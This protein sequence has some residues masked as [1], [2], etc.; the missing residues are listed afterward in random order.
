MKLTLSSADRIAPRPSGQGGGGWLRLLLYGVVVPF[1]LVAV[2][3]SGW[4]VVTGETPRDLVEAFLEG[5]RITL[6][7]PPHPGPEKPAAALLR[8][9]VVNDPDVKVALE[10]APP[11]P[12]PAAPAQGSSADSGPPPIALPA[13]PPL[14]SSPA[15]TPAAASPGAASFTPPPP[16]PPMAEPAI[17][18]GGEALAPPSFGQ[19]PSPKEDAKP[20]PAAPVSN[21][22]RNTA[23]G[24]LP[25]IAGGRRPWKVYARPAP[26]LAPGPRVAV[27][28]TGLGLSKDATAAAIAKLPADVSL[29]FSPYGSGLDGWIRRARE[30]GHEV[31]LDLPLEPPNY[32]QHDAGPMAVLADQ[33]PAEA[34]DHLEATL[35]RTA[36]YVGV[37]ASLHSPVAA[38]DSW[39]PMLQDLRNR[40]LL[41]VG[42]GLVGVP[43]ADMPAAASVTLV[44]DETPFR[45]AIDARLAR[46]LLAAGR[47][48]T[49]ITT[50]SARP[51]SFERL[52]AWLASLPE[53]GVTLVPV[54]AL[55]RPEP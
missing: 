27:V 36:G 5:P 17:P 24:P 39:G 13:T 21:L 48:G 10:A 52:L 8:P 6:P 11:A 45:V 34:V 47:D 41:F 32:P 4:Y 7:M 18:P 20:L 50:I 35:G 29:S 23:N 14:T 3:F 19:L 12:P 53:K 9:P 28:V 31:L 30:R 22:L 43:D 37:A 46:L 16:P 15:A 54:S 38:S 1:T 51:V 25:I 42:D 2:S 33:P 40:G 49:A 26:V 55:V 44:A